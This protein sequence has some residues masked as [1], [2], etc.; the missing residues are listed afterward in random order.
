[1]SQQNPL[2]EEMIFEDAAPVRIPVRI[3]GTDY[4]LC[5]VSEGGATQWHNKRLA[6]TKMING[7]LASLEGMA[8]LEPLL[9]SLCLF[10]PK[11]DSKSDKV[12]DVPVPIQ[13]VRGFPHKIV[14]Q[15]FERA[16]L[17][18]GLQQTDTIEIVKARIKTDTEILKR[19]EEGEESKTEEALKNSPPDSTPT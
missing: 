5:E 3:K 1:M 6:S 2:L 10:Q 12:T 11:T 4:V 7:Q 17:I 19:L 16:K 13:V 18:S 15:I 14:K 9:V 8:E